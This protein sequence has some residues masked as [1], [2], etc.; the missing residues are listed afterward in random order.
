M[1]HDS[2]IDVTTI[3]NAIVDII[4]QCNDSFLEEF[5]II[6]SSM[7][8]IDEE[9]SKTL[10][11]NLKTT[12]I[13]SGGSAA[14]TAVGIASFGSKAAFIGKVKMMNS[15]ILLKMILKELVYLLRHL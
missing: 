11:D 12:T 15:G 9:R 2:K 8:L 3:G 1:E 14:N 4:A 7:D 10:F 13:V 5:K 6:K